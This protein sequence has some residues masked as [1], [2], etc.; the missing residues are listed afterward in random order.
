MAR[1]LLLLAI[2]GLVVY[3]VADIASSDDDDRL[4]VPVFGWIV[5]VILLPVVGALGWIAVSRRQR[6][7]RAG[8]RPGSAGR[9][10]PQHPDGRPLAPDDDPEFLWLLEQ[11]RRKRQQ[12]DQQAAG[13]P[14]AAGSAEPAADEDTGDEEHLDPDAPGTGPRG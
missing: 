3:A 5:I 8:A 4:D 7:R 10:G 2:I 11:A 14:D 6:S 12:E 1:A 9:P 13:A